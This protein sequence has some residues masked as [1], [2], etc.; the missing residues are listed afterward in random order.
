MRYVTYKSIRFKRGLHAFGFQG[1]FKRGLD[2]ENDVSGSLVPEM[3][4]KF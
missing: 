2:A 3:W 4:L 1:T